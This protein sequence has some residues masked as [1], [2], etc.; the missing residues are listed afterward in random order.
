MVG[1]A[2][3]LI[4]VGRRVYAHLHHC[5]PDPRRRDAAL[6]DGRSGGSGGCRAGDPA[7]RERHAL[8]PGGRA[9]ERDELRAAV[10]QAEPFIALRTARPRASEAVCGAHAAIGTTQRSPM[11]TR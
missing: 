1:L 2:M 6:R 7:I 8:R 4:I 11:P 5:F 3:F 9:M 10:A